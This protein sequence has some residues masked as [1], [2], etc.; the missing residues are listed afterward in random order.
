MWGRAPVWDGRPEAQCLYWIDIDGRTLFRLSWR[1]HCMDRWELGALFPYMGRPGCIAPCASGRLLIAAETGFY[2]AAFQTCSC[3]ICTGVIAS[4]PDSS[5][6]QS[7]HPQACAAAQAEPGAGDSSLCSASSPNMYPSVNRC[8]ALLIH[9][10]GRVAT[11]RAVLQAIAVPLLLGGSRS[12]C[13]CR[14]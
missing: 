9:L 2:L 1:T 3:A 11:N 7:R 14:G 10:L 13:V 8:T 6:D 4:I 12:D 5:Q